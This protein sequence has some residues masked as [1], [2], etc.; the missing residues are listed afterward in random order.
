ML[1]RAVI[2]DS[3]PHLLAMRWWIK[4]F[5]P[6]GGL[7]GAFPGVDFFAGKQNLGEADLVLV[8]GDGT[9]ILGECK[10][11]G[12]GLTSEDLTKLEALEERLKSPWTFVATPDWAVNCG[13]IW[14]DAQRG[15]PER[16]R[17]V[18]TGE[19]LLDPDVRHVIPVDEDR[20]AWEELSRD[21]QTER[22]RQFAAGD[23]A[24]RR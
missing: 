9:L 23:W 22:E 24:R 6:G 20:F 21:E 17:F 15:L 12:R 14:R 4:V 19:K 18:L 13:P 1:L 10:L 11:T 3:L 7:Y 5:G 2:Q 8:L 16:P